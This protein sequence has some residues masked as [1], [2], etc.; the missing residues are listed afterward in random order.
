M[1]SLPTGTVTFLFTDI[2]GSTPRWE[3]YPAAM[4]A[5]LA[6]HDTLLRAA[7]SAHGGTVLQTAGDSFVAV[8]AQ[9]PD[10]LAAAL[11]GQRAL[12]AAPWAAPIGALRVRAALHSGPGE[13]RADGDHAEFTLNRLARLLATGRGGQIL[14]TATTRQLLNGGVDGLGWR[15]LGECWLKDVIRPL[16]VYQVLAPDLP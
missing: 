11:A 9:A 4:K 13:Q 8:F 3:Q 12:Q 5:A 10:A 15:D 2:E 14:V 6:Q 7:F 1:N 16:H